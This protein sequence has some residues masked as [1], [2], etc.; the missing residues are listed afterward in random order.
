MVV[1]AYIKLKRRRFGK[2]RTQERTKYGHIK[3]VLIRWLWKIST[4]ATPVPA[5]YIPNFCSVIL[6]AISQQRR[7]EFYFDPSTFVL[8]SYRDRLFQ[9]CFPQRSNLRIF[10]RTLFWDGCCCSAVHSPQ[11]PAL[12]CLLYLIFTINE[13]VAY[14]S[15]SVFAWYL[16]TVELYFLLQWVVLFL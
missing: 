2:E 9:T 14:S 16:F 4:A 5:W 1:L 8:C 11:L 10:E 12:Y 13:L 15:I 3:R 6:S 7:S